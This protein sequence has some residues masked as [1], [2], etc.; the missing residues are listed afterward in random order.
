MEY[1]LLGG[2]NDDAHHALELTRLL[3][4]LPVEVNLIPWS[5]S[6]DRDTK[7]LRTPRYLAQRNFNR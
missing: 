5:H 2:V 3:R 4:G 1:V 6:T 7:D